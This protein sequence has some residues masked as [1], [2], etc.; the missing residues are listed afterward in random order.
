MANSLSSKKRIRQNLNRQLR[1]RRR[2][3]SVKLVVR[4]FKD[5][6]SHGDTPAAAEA[7]KE[8]YKKIDQITAKG[9]LHKNTAARRKSSLAK[10][11]NTT[12]TK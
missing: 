2:K 10:Q 5:K 11:L 1:N 3:E 12:A 6:L 9:T 8:V 7:L 4:D